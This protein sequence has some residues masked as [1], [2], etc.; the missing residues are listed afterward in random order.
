MSA[1]ASPGAA[2]APDELVY[3]HEKT[4][5]G[6]AAV[7]SLL[8]WAVLIVGTLGIALIYV[9]LAFIIY[10]F[11]Q[12]G[13]I[14]YLRGNAVRITADQFPDLHARIQACCAKLGMAEPPSAFVYHAGGAFNAFAARFLGR[15]YLVLY[16]D[17][18]DAL[19]SSPDALNFYIGHELGHVRQGHL[20][21][22]PILFPA[23]I[24]PLLGAAYSRSR[25]YTCDLHGLACC[26]SREHAARALAALAAGGKR[27][28]TADLNRLS[29]ETQ[30]TSGFWMSFHELVAGYP[31]LVKRIARVLG[32]EHAGRI[33]SRNGFAYLFA[34]FVP[35]VGPGGAGGALIVIAIIGIMAAVAIPAYQDYTVRARVAQV[36]QE[37]NTATAAVTQHFERTKNVPASLEEAGFRPQTTAALGTWRVDE[38]GLIRFEFTISPVAGKTL[39]FVPSLDQNKRVVWRCAGETLEQRYLPQSCGGAPPP[40]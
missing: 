2:G 28:K 35:R 3:R 20:I 40:Q 8:F 12:S 17:V 32:P 34:L 11:A 13:L 27:W 39:V 37:G 19:E 30:A 29:A 21:W 10:L 1:V 36:L 26:P 9:L 5:F 6:I 14:S 24:L 23:M 25:E 31:W 16:A 15:H 33:P 38:R 4:L 22:G 18:V 7:I